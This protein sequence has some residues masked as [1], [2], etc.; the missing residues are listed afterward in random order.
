MANMMKMLKQAQGLQAQMQKVQAELAEREISF[1]SGGGM[2][3]VTA[4]CDGTVRDI[5]IDPKA[6]DPDD[7]DMLQDLVLA[8]VQGAVNQGKE[9]MASE[10]GELTKGMNIPGMPF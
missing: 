1:S 7:V 2:V 8:A 3:S 4:T 6:V 9:T 10:M 5:K